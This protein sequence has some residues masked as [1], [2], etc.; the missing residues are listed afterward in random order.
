MKNKFKSSNPI[1]NYT[2]LKH[3]ICC[4]KIGITT[5]DIAKCRICGKEQSFEEKILLDIVCP[6]CGEKIRAITNQKDIQ[7]FMCGDCK[8]YIDVEYDCRS[9]KVKNLLNF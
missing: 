2:R 3:F 1:A 6:E 9:N 4:N 7:F 8:T 5:N